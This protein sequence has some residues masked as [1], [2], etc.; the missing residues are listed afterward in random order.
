MSQASVQTGE[1]GRGPQAHSGAEGMGIPG[2]QTPP[3]APTACRGAGSMFS[4]TRVL[5]MR[6]FQK[7]NGETRH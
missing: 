4:Q 5:S 1:G 6:W 7:V 3:P 2:P